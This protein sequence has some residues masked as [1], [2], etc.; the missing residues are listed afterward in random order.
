MVLT[1]DSKF[2]QFEARP[3]RYEE[4]EGLSF[5]PKETIEEIICFENSKQAE[6]AFY[7]GTVKINDEYF[8]YKS[9]HGEDKELINELIGSY[10]ARKINLKAVDYKIGIY[11]GELY[12][13]SKI[14]YRPGYSYGDY[15]KLSRKVEKTDKRFDED[16]SLEAE[17]DVLNSISNWQMLINTLKLIAL[18]LKMG[19]VDRYKNLFVEMSKSTSQLDLALIF[20]C[21]YS[22]DLYED[23]KFTFY[24]NPLV[25]FGV[26]ESNLR[27]LIERYPILANYIE[28]MNA[29]PMDVILEDLQR[30]NGIYFTKEEKDKYISLDDE[31][32]KVLRKSIH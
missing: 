23:E 13:L 6:Y 5:L 31:Y 15:R 24:E 21:G 1:K 30:E 27:I 20:D 17:D 10:L 9:T 25:K 16:L 3:M 7:D 26:N 18:D 32:S 8:Y 11:N 12:A 2:I 19:Q 28:A 22:Y 29:L 14:F 4:A